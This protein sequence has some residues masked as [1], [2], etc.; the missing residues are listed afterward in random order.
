MTPTEQQIAGNIL[1]A[2]RMGGLRVKK[3]D[4][5]EDIKELY[6]NGYWDFEE[7][8]DWCADEDLPFHEDANWLLSAYAALGFNDMPTNIIEA[9]N[10]LVDQLRAQSN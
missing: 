1:I 4:V 3:E 6:P 8:S 5:S 7:G 9:W 2:E 10:S